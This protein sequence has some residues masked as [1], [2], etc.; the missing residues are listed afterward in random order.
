MRETNCTGLISFAE[1]NKDFI[2]HQYQR[3]MTF[4]DHIKKSVSV[5]NMIFLTLLS[6]ASKIQVY[7]DPKFRQNWSQ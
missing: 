2:K 7:E 6:R 4:H 5:S 1:Q 3:G